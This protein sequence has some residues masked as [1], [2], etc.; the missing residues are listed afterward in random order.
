SGATARTGRG[1]GRS[2]FLGLGLR[3]AQNAPK[4]GAGLHSIRG[5]GGPFMKLRGGE[6]ST[7]TTGNFQP[8][9][10]LRG[11]RASGGHKLASDGRN[12]DDA[13]LGQGT[14]YCRIRGQDGGRVDVSGRLFRLFSLYFFSREKFPKRASNASNPS[15]HIIPST[16][17]EMAPA[18]G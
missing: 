15:S 18:A 11:D 10:T 13:A 16:F 5:Q 8:E 12:F 7:G 6:F 1:G 3:Y 14:G 17:P 2:S 4:N 9:L